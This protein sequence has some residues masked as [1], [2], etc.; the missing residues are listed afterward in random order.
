MK[1]YEILSL[2]KELLQRLSM[3]G[4]FIISIFRASLILQIS[5]FDLYL[6]FC[7]S[8]ILICTNKCKLLTF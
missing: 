7:K 6:L 3:V 2:N 4:I 5:H 1:I 8:H